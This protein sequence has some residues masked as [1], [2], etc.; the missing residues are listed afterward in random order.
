MNEVA[1]VTLCSAPRLAHLRNQLRATAGVPRV[2][3]WIGDDEAPDLDAECVVHVPPGADGL[4]LAAARNAGARAAEALGARLLVFL[5]A[6]CVPGPE[7]IERYRSAAASHPMAV[8]CGPVTYLAAGAGLDPAS[9]R[10]ATAPH[11]A[12]PAPEPGVVQPAAPADYPLFWSL[13]FATASDVWRQIGGFDEAYEG[14]GGE[15]TDFAFSL[16]AGGVPM[17]WVGGAD[18]YHQYHETS[19]PPWQHLDDILRNGALFAR[20]WGEWP[21]TGWLEAFAAGGAIER[22]ASAEGGGW[23]RVPV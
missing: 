3:V 4:R 19:S 17:M 10:A 5:D 23:R 16:R 15:D 12:R 21:M 1:V 9:L 7:L 20:K 8:L 2:V 18:A 11:A 6:D 22:D 14:Y 13:S